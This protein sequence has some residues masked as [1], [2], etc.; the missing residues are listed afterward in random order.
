MKL[1]GKYLCDFESS[2]IEFDVDALPTIHQQAEISE[3]QSC[4]EAIWMGKSSF[5][6][7]GFSIQI[8]MDD[9]E[10]DDIDLLAKFMS[11]DDI[12]KIQELHEDSQRVRF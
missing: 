8:G 2:F 10:S 1:T 5:I 12:E 7:G 4:Y 6:E 9:C 11:E 3:E